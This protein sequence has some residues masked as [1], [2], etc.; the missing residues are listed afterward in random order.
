MNA[1][2]AT[3]TFPN[4]DDALTKAVQLTLAGIW[5]QM[6]P[7]TTVAPHVI[8]VRIEDSDQL[9]CV[10]EP[11]FVVIQEGGSS[12]ELYVHAH[13]NHDDALN[14]RL[15]CANEGSY[16]TTPV[17]EISPLLAVLG[18]HFYAAA[19]DLLSSLGDLAYAEP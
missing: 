2:V 15:D 14:D 9:E 7:P 16:R 1:T 3:R 19:E 11:A 5:F 12:S 8:A 4:Q 18:E 10:P 17:Y 13:A 6:S